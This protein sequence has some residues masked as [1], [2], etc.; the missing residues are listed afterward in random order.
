MYLYVQPSL[1]S[2]ILLNVNF[3][4]FQLQRSSQTP[5]STFSNFTFFNFQVF[6]DL[7]LLLFSTSTIVLR[8]NFYFFQLS[9]SCWTP[10]STFSNFKDRIEHQLLLFPTSDFTPNLNFPL[11]ST[12]IYSCIPNSYSRSQLFPTSG[13]TVPAAPAGCVI[14]T[15]RSLI[16]TIDGRLSYSKM[17]LILG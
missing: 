1:T 5:T 13:N 7:Q 12:S 2:K 10:T 6:V 3:Y 9:R 17:A 8:P 4:S 15:G 14:S 16:V 11:F